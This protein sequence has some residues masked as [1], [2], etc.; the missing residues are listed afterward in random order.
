MNKNK[1]V[2]PVNQGRL[3]YEQ[4]KATVKSILDA[5]VE[6]VT[7][8]DDSFKNIEQKIGKE[9]NG[10]IEINIE[11]LK[12]GACDFIAIIDDAE[13]MIREDL[14]NQAIKFGGETGG[15][16][17]GRKVRGYF[18]RGLKESIVALGEGIILTRKNSKLTGVKIWIE[19]RGRDAMPYYKEFT[20]EFPLLKSKD[21]LKEQDRIWKKIC[22]EIRI[23]Y[24]S[25]FC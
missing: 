18:G 13:G 8:C 14:L 17:E 12:G 9:K 10:T 2:L 16:K 19:G 4:A 22:D 1:S 25:S 6:L 7:N 11:R 15:R 5:V 24:K 23:V 21:K 3:V 20:D